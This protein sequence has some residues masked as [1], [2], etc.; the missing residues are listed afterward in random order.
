[1]NFYN[2]PSTLCLRLTNARSIM[3]GMSLGRIVANGLRF[4]CCVT[5][6]CLS[7]C[8]KQPIPSVPS[9]VTNQC[10]MSCTQRFATCQKKC[11]NNCSRC[12]AKANFSAS[13]QQE[14]QAHEVQI[15]GGFITR[16]LKSFRDPLQCR[17]ITCDCAADL[18]TCSQACTG[19]ISKQLRTVPYCT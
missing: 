18:N 3:N 11:V 1:M 4:L 5:L 7:G 10:K 6:V 16:E 14:K 2:N 12:T 9:F 13:V 8:A 19:V 17:K 15:Q